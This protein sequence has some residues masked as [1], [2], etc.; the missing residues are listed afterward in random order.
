MRALVCVPGEELL[1]VLLTLGLRLVLHLQVHGGEAQLVSVLHGHLV[2]LQAAAH[3]EAAPHCGH[4]V[5]EPLA[6]DFVVEAQ[7]AEL[8]LH[9]ERRRGE[10][11]DEVCYRSAWRLRV[12]SELVQGS[13]IGLNFFFFI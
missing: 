11:G 6:G 5:V 2:L 12:E 4:L 9:T 10:G 1:L 7:P 3:A 8:D 13:N